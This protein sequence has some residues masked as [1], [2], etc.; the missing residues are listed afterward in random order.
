MDITVR[1]DRR[2][3][4]RGRA[5]C[6]SGPRLPFTGG[7]DP[8]RRRPSVNKAARK[9]KFAVRGYTRCQRCGRPHAVYRKFGLCRICLR[10][11]AH[12][13][14]L[15]GITKSPGN[16]SDRTTGPMRPPRAPRGNHDEK[17]TDT[18]M[19][20][21]DPIADMLTRVC[22][23]PTRRTTTPSRCRSSTLKTR[24]AEIL[25]QEGYIAGC[26]V[27]DDENGVGR[28]LVLDLKYG[29]NRE[30]IDRRRAPGVQARP[31]RL[32][33]VDRAAEGA[34]RP[35]RGDHLDVDRAADRPAGSQE[36]RGWG[37]PRLR[38]VAGG[39][40]ACRASDGFP[41]PFPAG[42]T[43]PS[44]ARTSRSRAQGRAGSHRRL[45]HQHPRGPTTAASRSPGPTT[46]ASAARC[47]G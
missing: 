2:D 37:S 44:R 13:G 26:A 38:L 11:M 16:P 1:D 21:T 40:S 43:S 29:P 35:R 27:A 12:R 9:P 3:R 17:G 25:Q 23:T 46:S 7:A 10:E 31:A 6:S 45:A 4:R 5:P 39:E 34:R 41:S 20:M 22:A 47:T 36:G 18:T 30:R 15:P 28:T 33:E 42:S 24:I 19:T 14:E 32:R 8:W